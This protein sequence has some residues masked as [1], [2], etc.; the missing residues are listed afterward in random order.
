MRRANSLVDFDNRPDG[1]FD[2]DGIG[3][4]TLRFRCALAYWDI[5][6]QPLPDPVGKEFFQR[7]SFT[8][9]EAIPV[10]IHNP[11]ASRPEGLPP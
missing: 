1:E 8:Y 9:T 7:V 5:E 10:R 2:F 6:G 11:A 4:E 3:P